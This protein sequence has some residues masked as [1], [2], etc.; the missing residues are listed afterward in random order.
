[1]SK[2]CQNVS[3]VPRGHLTR[4]QVCLP[5]VV[6]VDFW[7]SGVALIIRFAQINGG[8]RDKTTNRSKHRDAVAD[9]IVD[10]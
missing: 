5:V 8:S 6:V 10:S 4:A 2:F 7:R 9:P 1:M 3:T